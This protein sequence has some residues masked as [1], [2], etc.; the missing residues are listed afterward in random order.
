MPRMYML[1]CLDALS[2]SK[3]VKQD[4]DMKGENIVIL[5][6]NLHNAR[7]HIMTINPKTKITGHP[8]ILSQKCCCTKFEKCKDY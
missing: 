7:L 8:V 5:Y 2:K 6:M 3:S 4:P 1:L